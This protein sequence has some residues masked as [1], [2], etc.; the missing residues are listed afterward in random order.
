[1]CSKPF[2]PLQFHRFQSKL[3][4]SCLENCFPA[5]AS[6]RAAYAVAAS[7]VWA[8][9]LRG[10]RK[11]NTWSHEQQPSTLTSGGW[12]PYV[13]HSGIRDDWLIYFF[14]LIMPL[15]LD[16]TTTTAGCWGS[17]ADGAAFWRC[18][19]GLIPFWPDSAQGGKQ[20]KATA[21]PEGSWK[22]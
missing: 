5:S 8:S 11:T 4:I 12:V 19:Q 20:S 7:Y 17:A 22:W 21:R 6:E 15:C 1:M 10:G 18:T 13:T 2:K 3:S 9:H 14:S 16:G